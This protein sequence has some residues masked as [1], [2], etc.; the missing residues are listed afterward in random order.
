MPL[1]PSVVFTKSAMAI[2]PTKEDIRADSPYHNS[3]IKL[4]LKLAT[5]EAK[6]LCDF[7]IG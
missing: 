3:T 4:I 2:A 7:S 6:N 1:G 5:K